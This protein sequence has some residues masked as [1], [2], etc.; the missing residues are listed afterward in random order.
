MD[1]SRLPGP[2]P[3]QYG[4]TEH[5]GLPRRPEGRRVGPQRVLNDPVDSG[6]CLH[7]TWHH[8]RVPLAARRSPLPCHVRRADWFLAQTACPTSCTCTACQPGWLPAVRPRRH[9]RGLW[10]REG[11]LCSF[12]VSHAAYMFQD[13]QTP[14]IRTQAS[15]ASTERGHASAAPQTQCASATQLFLL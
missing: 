13:F 15:R 4:H 12:W 6:S 14:C 8:L 5:C 10:V 11:R 2:R 7:G 3:E 9:I 1:T